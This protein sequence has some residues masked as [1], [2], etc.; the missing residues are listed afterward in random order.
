[1]CVYLLYPPRSRFDSAA[2]W[3]IKLLEWNH[4]HRNRRAESTYL[5]IIPSPLAFDLINLW[6]FRQKYT[7]PFVSLSVKWTKTGTSLNN[8]W[9][10]TKRFLALSIRCSI[11]VYY[12]LCIQFVQGDWR[13]WNSFSVDYTEIKGI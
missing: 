6:K 2:K 9:V 8:D 5:H 4:H 3:I 12:I 7:T 1:L 11:A 13:P 10:K